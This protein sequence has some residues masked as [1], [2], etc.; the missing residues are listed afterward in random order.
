MQNLLLQGKKICQKSALGTVAQHAM[1]PADSALCQIAN[2]HWQRANIIW[3]EMARETQSQQNGTCGK[4]KL[5]ALCYVH[6]AFVWDSTFYQNWYNK[7][8]I[9]TWWIQVQIKTRR[10]Q[11]LRTLKI[12]LKSLVDFSKEKNT[13]M[14]K[15]NFS[16]DILVL[17][18]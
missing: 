14:L 11:P 16:L 17:L 6:T 4:E 10:T 15:W 12:L 1:F 9:I 18:F 5:W 7:C 13:Y 2:G 8:I 3:Q